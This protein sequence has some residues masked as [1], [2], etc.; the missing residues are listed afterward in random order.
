M[1]QH[2]IF[3]WRVS[4]GTGGATADTYHQG[5]HFAFLIV[6]QMCLM[7]EQSLCF[8]QGAPAGILKARLCKLW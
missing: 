1:L 3:E 7:A 5:A 8:E 2:Y 6:L 4:G